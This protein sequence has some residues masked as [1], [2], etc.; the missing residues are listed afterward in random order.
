MWLFVFLIVHK[1]YCWREFCSNEKKCDY[2]LV[3]L[4]GKFLVIILFLVESFKLLLIKG[5]NYTGFLFVKILLIRH[6]R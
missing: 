1:L 3:L 2:G 5:Y 6:K 4:M